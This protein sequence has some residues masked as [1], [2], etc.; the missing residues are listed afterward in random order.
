MAL[1]TFEEVDALASAAE[2]QQPA[3]PSFEEVDA[4]ASAAPAPTALGT[5]TE[6]TGLPDEAFTRPAK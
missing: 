3:I 6:S 5:G 4:L 2:P 1:P